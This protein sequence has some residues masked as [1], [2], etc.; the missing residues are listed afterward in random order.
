MVLGAIWSKLDSVHH[1][2][3]RLREIKIR[4][5]LS[6]SA[7][8]KWTK[9]SP[10]NLPLYLEILDYFF[11]ND[12]LCFRALIADKGDLRHGQFEQTHDEWYYKMYFDMLK[13]IL[14]PEDRFRIYLDIKDTRSSSKI[15]KLHEVL[16]NNL[17]DFSRD[18]VERVQTVRSH[19]AELLQLADLLIGAVSAANRP[20]SIQSSAKR[21]CVERVRQRSR[22]SLTQSTLLRERRFNLFHWR[23][24]S[25]AS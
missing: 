14:Q 6:R 20:L 9:V 16:A 22:Y 23:G 25:S 5:G 19:E 1:S 7:E 21:A 11:D 3:E 17:Y 4:H 12:Q 13:W 18:I 2:T 10:G 8:L 24:L 15:R